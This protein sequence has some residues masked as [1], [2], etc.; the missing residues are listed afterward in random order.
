MF[1][2]QYLELTGREADYYIGADYDAA[3]IIALS[4][5]QT[6]STNATIIAN[7]ITDVSRNYF[8]VTGRVNLDVNGDRI[9]EYCEVRGQGI[10]ED[11]PAMIMYGEYYGASRTML[12]Y[13]EVLI[14][15]K[16][17]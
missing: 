8:G 12:W 9:P 16:I 11:E 1:A 4:I 5:L 14:E 3:W 7:C 17:K 2:S 13:D 6:R 10:Q 15:Q